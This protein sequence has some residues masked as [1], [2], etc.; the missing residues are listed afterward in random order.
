MMMNPNQMDAMMAHAEPEAY[1]ASI[2]HRSQPAATAADL[3]DQG[4]VA[5]QNGGV[6][7]AAARANLQA[8]SQEDAMALEDRRGG[9]AGSVTAGGPPKREPT[10]GKRAFERGVQRTKTAREGIALLRRGSAVKKYG[11]QGR[12]HTTTFWL[13]ADETTLGWVGKGGLLGKRRAV[14]VA[15]VVEVLEG[16]Q[17]AVFKKLS[18]EGKG[19]ERKAS[20]SE[21]SLGAEHLSLSLR[22]RGGGNDQ[23]ETLDLSCD[24]E[25]TFGLWVAALRALIGERSSGAAPRPS[26]DHLSASELSA[27]AHEDAPPPYTTAA[28]A[29]GPPPAVLEDSG[30]EVG[31]DPDQVLARAGSRGSV[32]DPFRAALPSSPLAAGGEEGKEKALAQLVEMG[33]ARGAAEV[34][35]ARAGGDGEA[36]LELLLSG[37]VESI[38]LGP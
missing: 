18:G 33:F 35:L 6:L 7:S 19:G 37:A 34:A 36:A 10:F 28:P 24:D 27:L 25:E 11:R 3:L 31:F 2:A 29:G 20:L 9:A 12:P 16:Q 4:T 13:S 17:S 38:G 8:I 5:Q 22:L 14:A 32:S 1:A 21:R 15:D 26:V 23:K 30:E